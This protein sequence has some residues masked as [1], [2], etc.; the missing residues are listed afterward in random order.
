[1]K[2]GTLVWL[3][4]FALYAATLGLDSFGDSDYGGDEPHYLLTAESLVEDG[5][6]DLVDDYRDREYAD[7][8]PYPLDPHGALTEGR[9]HEPHGVGFPLLIAPAYA[10]GGELA[11][12]LFL[13]ALA[14]L[15]GAL[16]YLLALRVAPDPWALGA[17]LAV[18]VAPPALA[19]GSAVYPELTAGA[20]L[21]GA[22]L[23]ALR[24]HERVRRR[25]ALACF[26]LL[27]ALPWLGTKYVPAGI[28]IGALAMR[29]LLWQGRGTLALVGAEV[30]GFSA[31]VYVSV[32]DALYGGITPYAADVPGET[33]TDTGFPTGYLERSYR[34]V[35][36]FI[37][38]DYGLLRWAPVVALA[39]L[40]LWLAYRARRE[41]LARLVPEHR[42]AEAAAGM[43]ALAAGAQVLVAAFLA[44][45]MFGFWFPGRHLVAALPLAVPLVAWGLRHAPRTG[46]ALAALGLAAS[47]WLYVDVRAGGGGL[48]AVVPDA[49]WGPL[50]AAFPLFDGSAVPNAVA[51]AVA[52]GLL[53][54]LIA[55][56]RH[57]RQ[58]AGA[59][60]T[61]YSG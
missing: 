35:A 31:A 10:L 36:L 61:R 59:T 22:A 58:T 13:A 28:V 20:V 54:L 3:V 39:F 47:A 45:T 33:A 1:V 46:A 6:A 32:N 17:A 42:R 5:D 55:D 40:G 9:L 21:A 30:A 48:A 44:P 25:D 26:A 19:Y 4:L 50:E 51:A 14:A 29:P 8:Y 24:L 53:A 57:W 60:R 37:D 43:C 49:P 56:A 15:A 16:A 52:A 23:L 2:R 38:R 7:S 41:G 18:G 12:E 27:G 11:V 34:L